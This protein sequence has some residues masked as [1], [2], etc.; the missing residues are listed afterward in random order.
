M[1]IQTDDDAL[2]EFFDADVVPAADER[3]CDRSDYRLEF[4]ENNLAQCKREVGEAYVAKYDAFRRR[5]ANT[6]SAT[7]PDS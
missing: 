3:A 2:V 4:S 1:H 5:E 7:A 6:E